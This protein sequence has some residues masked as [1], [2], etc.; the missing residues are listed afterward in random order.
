MRQVQANKMEMP[1][2]AFSKINPH[3]CEDSVWS[4]NKTDAVISFCCEVDDKAKI[5]SDMT[6][7]QFLEIVNLTQNNWVRYGKNVDRCTQPWLSH[8]V[9]NTINVRSDEWEGVGDYIFNNQDSFTAVSLLGMTGDKD[10]AQ[11]PFQAVYT[12]DEIDQT[13]GPDA[14]RQAVDLVAK[15]VEV[16]GNLWTACDTVMSD[17]ILGEVIDKGDGKADWVIA[18][19]LWAEQCQGLGG[20]RRTATYC[21]KDVYNIAKF[22]KL[23][24]NY[25][26]VDYVSV[27]ENED[28]TTIQ[29]TLACSNGTCELNF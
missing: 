12:Q 13:Y 18:V 27:I 1:F 26:D 20:D 22:E 23:K 6:A 28:N 14:T 29:E 9:S 16:F 21:L 7:T 10:Y 3:A 17:Q 24:S 2:L 5:N 25:R 15:G 4:A 19:R 11:A 8:N